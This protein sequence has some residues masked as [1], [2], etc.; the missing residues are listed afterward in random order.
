VFR[1]V[2][3]VVAAIAS[4]G[5]VAGLAFAVAGGSNSTSTV[6]AVAGAPVP[7]PP[8]ANSGALTIDQI[9]RRDGPGVVDIKVA[10][11][12]T[13][14]LGIT[15]ETEA[16]GAGVVYDTDGDILTDEHVVAGANSVKVTFSDGHV[17]GASV[18]GTDASTYVAMI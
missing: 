9:Y 16:E 15:P 11:T 3:P 13:G 6:Q 18:V 1:R 10:A 17:A 4:A 2:S 5:A 12:A 7:A 14:P 8:A